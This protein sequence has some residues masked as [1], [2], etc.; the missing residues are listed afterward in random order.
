MVTLKA[1]G[2]RTFEH[3]DQTAAVVSRMLLDLEHNGMDAVRSYSRSLDQ[4]DPP[5]FELDAREIQ[6]AI[7]RC[8]DQLRADTR[9]CQDN[10]RSFAKAQLATMHELEVETMPGVVL[11]H[12]HIPVASVGSYIPGGRY[13]MFGS[14]QMS[15]IPAKVAGVATISACTPPVKGEG[16]TRRPSTPSLKR[17]PTGYSCLAACKPLP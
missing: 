9:F 2:H 5:S 12:K 13:P 4:W 14:A 17:D 8:D 11:G 1:G 16:I 3:D 7:E 15:I 10:V 6:Q